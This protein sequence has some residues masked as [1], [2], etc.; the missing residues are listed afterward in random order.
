[1]DYFEKVNKE[2]GITILCNLHFL[3]LVRRY[4]PQVIAL[5]AGQKVFEGSS[6]EI[7]EAWFARIYGEDAKEV[8]IR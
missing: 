4:T 6:K 7:D 3:S 1:M 8:Q 2:M 5:K